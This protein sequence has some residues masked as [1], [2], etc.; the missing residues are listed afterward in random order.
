VRPTVW[1]ALLAL[2]S[3][4][5]GPP[6]RR[7]TTAHAASIGSPV[8][9][10][11]IAQL[12]TMS[13]EWRDATLSQAIDDAGQT[14]SKVTNVGYQQTYKGLAMWVAT[15]PESGRW[16]LFIDG[17]GYAQVRQCAAAAQAGLPPCAR[18][19]G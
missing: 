15:C 14:C 5:G 19:S 10:S 4:C 7:S 16:A 18:S 13:P 8:P 2:L 11:A 1:L 17:H 9:S 12:R 6:E 3:A